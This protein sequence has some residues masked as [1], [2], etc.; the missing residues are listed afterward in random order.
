MVSTNMFNAAYFGPKAVISAIV[1]SLIVIQIMKFFMDKNITI[2][3][4]EGVPPMVSNSF[5]SLIPAVV[6]V[7]VFGLIKYGFS[8]THFKTFND[9]IYTIIQTPLQS[10][11]GSFP[12]FILLLVIAQILWFFGIHGDNMMSAVTTPITTAAIAANADLFTGGG[13]D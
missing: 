6:I 5:T 8:I 12:A 10:L 7:L 4:P 1:V 9:F 11:V 13:K 2:K 3:M